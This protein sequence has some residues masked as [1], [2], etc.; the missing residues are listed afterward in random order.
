MTNN[1]M[2]T[3]RALYE[4]PETWVVEVNT[5]GIICE[6]GD[7]GPTGNRQDYGGPI[8]RNY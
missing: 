2:R 5:E 3:D 7:A 1:G 8:E 6:S 4:A